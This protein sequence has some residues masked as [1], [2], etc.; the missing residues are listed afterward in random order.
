MGDGAQNK[1]KED[2]KMFLAEG[3]WALTEA[4]RYRKER[5]GIEKTNFRET[6]V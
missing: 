2:I 5:K 6:S 1:N 4:Q 3:K